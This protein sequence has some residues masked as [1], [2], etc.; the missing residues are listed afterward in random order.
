MINPN[1]PCYFL[2]ELESA[3]TNIASIVSPSIMD[4]IEKGYLFSKQYDSDIS[5]GIDF[6]DTT[7]FVESLAAPNTITSVENQLNKLYTPIPK[8]EVAELFT[9]SDSEDGMLKFNTMDGDLFSI[10]SLTIKERSGNYLQGK[11]LYKP[12]EPPSLQEML[13]APPTFIN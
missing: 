3:A 2:I 9:E 8:Q 11:L 4:D 12:F 7:E 5:A 6:H 10:E 13:D 1:A